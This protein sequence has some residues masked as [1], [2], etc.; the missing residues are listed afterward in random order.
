MAVVVA[1]GIGSAGPT[2]S[3]NIAKIVVVQTAAGYAPNPGHEGKGIVVAARAYLLR[4]VPAVAL[5]QRPHANPFVLFR[6]HGG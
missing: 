3:G 6:H 5:R 1:T 2:S 4:N